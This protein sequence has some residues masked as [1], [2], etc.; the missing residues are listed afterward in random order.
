MS[1]QKLPPSLLRNLIVDNSP[2]WTKFER[3]GFDLMFHSNE[4]RVNNG[5][6]LFK[7]VPIEMEDD[8]DII[9]IKLEI[10]KE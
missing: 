3:N 1:L 9:L 2:W 8:Q 6:D 4:S 7:V 5:L 10:K